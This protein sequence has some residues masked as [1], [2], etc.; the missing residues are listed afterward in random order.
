MSIKGNLHFVSLLVSGAISGIGQVIL[1]AGVNSYLAAPG[2]LLS[3]LVSVLVT[4]NRHGG[5][6]S[7]LVDNVM[8]FAGNVVF[9]Y[10]LAFG[11]LKIA[12]ELRMRKKNRSA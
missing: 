1:L 2:L 3:A 12:N 6:R 5:F 9:Y 7:E 8:V 4:G 10:L 11:C